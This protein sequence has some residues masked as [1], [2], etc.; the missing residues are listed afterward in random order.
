MS[1]GPT[2]TLGGPT[3]T[4]SLA[5]STTTNM[6]AE[7]FVFQRCTKY[8]GTTVDEFA[9]VATPTQLEEL[10]VGCPGAGTSYF[11]MGSVQLT[12]QSAQE[13]LSVYRQLLQQ[14]NQLCADMD[15]LD[16]ISQMPV[17]ISLAAGS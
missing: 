6:P 4:M 2:I 3:Y 5:V 17:T 8:D 1:Q 13:L 10:E 11:R 7:V 9:A 16:Q 14:V 12:S 15:A